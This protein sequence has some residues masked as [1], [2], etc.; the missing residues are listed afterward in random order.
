MAGVQFTHAGAL[1]RPTASA[2]RD[3]CA[4]TLATGLL[5]RAYIP[6]RH[7]PG[8]NVIYAATSALLWEEQARANGN[9]TMIQYDPP[10]YVGLRGEADYR[11]DVDVTSFVAGAGPAADAARRLTL[12][13]GV[14]FAGAAAPELLTPDAAAESF[15]YAYLWKHLVYD[16]RPG[17]VT[18]VAADGDT[19]VIDVPTASPDERLVVASG[20]RLETF[21]DTIVAAV[22]APTVPSGA[23]AAWTLE[24][25]A[26]PRIHFDL[27]WKF[28]TAFLRYHFKLDAHGATLLSEAALRPFPLSS[29][30]V[31][32]PSEPMRPLLVA[33]MRRGA[34]RPYFAL[35]LE[36]TEL[37]LPD[38]A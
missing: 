24:R 7:E 9:T 38:P 34:R 27:R 17:I 4:A 6:C 16:E 31:T 8:K 10:V 22:G 3:E 33:L 28:R 11:N 13:V 15:A 19:F 35:W 30:I 25:F 20:P 5:D 37:L 36:N 23:P 2:V 18:R 14:H 26:I 32:R 1:G 12:E 21:A 29:M